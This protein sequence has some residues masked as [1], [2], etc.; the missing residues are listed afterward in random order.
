[1][2]AQLTQ[3]ADQ[4]SAEVQTNFEDWDDESQGAW[5]TEKQSKGRLL[6]VL[7]ANRGTCIKAIESGSEIHWT[8]DG[9][10]Y[11]CSSLPHHWTYLR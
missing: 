7:S 10:F 1:M 5:N 9:D 2:V 3:N 4:D 8:Q 11:V 6:C